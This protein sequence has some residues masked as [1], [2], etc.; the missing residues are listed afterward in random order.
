MKY[1]DVMY[2]DLTCESLAWHVTL[3][4]SRVV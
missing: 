4:A 3:P 1:F 2:C